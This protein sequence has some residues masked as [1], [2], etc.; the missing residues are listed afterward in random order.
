M[1]VAIPVIELPGVGTDIGESH[2]GMV[3]QALP[4][5]RVFL[6]RNAE[7]MAAQGVDPTVM[8]VWATGGH[9]NATEYCMASKNLKWIH[10]LS[11][12]VEGIT[13]TAVASIPG[14]ILTNSK[15]IHGIPISEH[16]MGFMINHYRGLSRN[17]T[18]QAAR[19]WERFMPDE[20]YGKTVTIL[21]MGSIATDVAKRAKAFGMTVIGVKRT[22]SA[23]EY[24]DEILPSDRMDEAISRADT[25]VMLLP[26]TNETNN[27]MDAGKFSLMKDGAFF[28]NVSR[29]STVDT[30]ALMVA[31]RSGK[32]SGAA[33]DVYDP[34][35]LP[36]GH[37][38]WDMDNVFIC[39][40]MSAISPHYLERAFKVF[41]ENVPYFLKGE[42][43][44]T[45]IDI[46][47]Y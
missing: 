18:S 46:E 33:L 12:G 28:I 23:N 11:A 24:V 6:T 1:D 37:P 5:A 7:E 21:G 13:R 43:L 14:L 30:D 3:R 34:E 45:Q 40:H 16:V 35:P 29:A 42:R 39:P 25:L 27:I 4:D 15:G 17:L 31:L 32:L 19:L 9:F 44:P 10:A 36:V 41:Q 38:L 26:A 8:I 2:V 22:V 47:K 20:L